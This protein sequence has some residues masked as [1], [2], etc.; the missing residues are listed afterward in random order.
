MDANNIG[1]QA[2]GSK[3][4]PIRLYLNDGATVVGAAVVASV[5]GTTDSTK[6]VQ[7]LYS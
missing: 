1:N 2:L 6:K 5:H 3:A 7:S 4:S